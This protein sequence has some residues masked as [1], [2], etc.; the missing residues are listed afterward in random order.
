MNTA[1][2]AALVLIPVIGEALAGTCM[3]G[4]LMT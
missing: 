1:E 4:A 2:C 3:V